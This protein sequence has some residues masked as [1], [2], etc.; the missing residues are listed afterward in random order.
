[1]HLF[2]LTFSELEI[3]PNNQKALFANIKVL[4][5]DNDSSFQGVYV[6]LCCTKLHA[7]R[8][9][10]LI[11]LI[12]VMARHPDV[13][14]TMFGRKTISTIKSIEA[15]PCLYYVNYP[16]IPRKLWIL[17]ICCEDNTMWHCLA[18]WDGKNTVVLW[19]NHQ[20]VSKKML[21]IFRSFLKKKKKFDWKEFIFM[22]QLFSGWIWVCSFSSHSRIF[23]SYGDVTIAGERLQILTYDRH[24]WPLSSENSLACHTYM[25]C[26]GAFIYNGHL[27]GPMTIT[28]IA[29]VCQWSCHYLRSVANGI[30]TPNLPLARRTI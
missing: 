26:V 1:M 8:A 11:L 25:Y 15:P 14:I 2:F 23:H 24:S 19:I 13:R 30:R 5:E 10:L 20:Q 9:D 29:E 27:W 22:D 12:F 4:K 6:Y 16:A 3:S 17:T 7:L 28:P 18:I 21:N